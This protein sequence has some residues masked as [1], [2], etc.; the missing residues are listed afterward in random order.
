MAPEFS[1][2]SQLQLLASSLA[3]MATR[4]ISSCFLLT[5]LAIFPSLLLPTSCNGGAKPGAAPPPEKNHAAFFIFGDSL[6]DA[7]NNQFLNGTEMGKAASSWPYGET[8]FRGPTGR[9]SDGRL[10]PDFIAEYANLP[11]IPPYLNPKVKK[12]TDGVNFASAGAGVLRETSPS[13]MDL[14]K[15]LNCFKKAEKQ[16]RKQLGDAKIEKLLSNAVYMFGMGGNDYMAFLDTLTTPPHSDVTKSPLARKYVEMVLGNLTFVIADVYKMGGRKFVIQ[17]VAPLGCIPGVKASLLPAEEE[18]G[19]DGGGSRD[20]SSKREKCAKGPSWLAR[21]HNDALSKLLHKLASKLP[22][23]KYVLFDYYSNL[24]VRTLYGKKFGFEVGESACCG[25]GPYRGEATCGG[26]PP[27]KKGKQSSQKG[28]GKAVKYE[29]CQDP[30][31]YVWFD[32]A[33]P[34]EQ[35]NSQLAQILWSGSPPDVVPHSLKPLFQCDDDHH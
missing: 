9:S 31:K 33:H 24:A 27:P 35:T 34:T 5:S 19:D 25:S 2:Y 4:L 21:M 6:L 14:G 16:L 8:F 3:L 15:Q 29:L 11:L 32:A 22:Q 1:H 7:G 30:K 23:F 18:G 20:K 17:N 13:T 26:H 12:Y 10:I 28:G